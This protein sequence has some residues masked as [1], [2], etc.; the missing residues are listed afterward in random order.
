MQT[1]HRR[2]VHPYARS[3]AL[4]VWRDMATSIEIPRSAWNGFLRRLAERHRG[5]LVRVAGASCA[6]PTA[7]RHARPA[8]FHDARLG[9]RLDGSEE[10]LVTVGEP[11]YMLEPYFVVEPCQIRVVHPLPS[12]LAIRI[13]S[14][15]PSALV[16][17]F[18]LQHGR[19]TGPLALVSASREGVECR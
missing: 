10:I 7:P 1:A 15:A 11:P 9:T 3:A 6:S 12:V 16:L 4:E 14:G 2:D 8:R 17:T 13:E 18:V 19:R 5:E